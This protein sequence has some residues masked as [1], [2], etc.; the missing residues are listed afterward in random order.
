[1]NTGPPKRWKRWLLYA[2]LAVFVPVVTLV[3]VVQ[4]GLAER[5]MRGAIVGG[6]ERITGGQVQLGAFRFSFRA[7]RAELDDLT[8]HGLEPE[9]A[10]PLFHAEHI[11][12]DIRVLSFLRGKVAPEEV[13][14]DRPAVHLRFDENGRSN[15]P[16]PQ[17][18]AR[19]PGEPLQRRIFDVGIRRL[20]LNNGTLLFNQTRM[21]LVAQ[22]GEFNFALDIREPVPGQR[23]YVCD[24]RWEH[25]TLVIRRYLPF[26]SDL[27]AKL[28]LTRNSLD[29][30]ELRW[31]LPHSEFKVA[32]NLA[33]FA[34]PAWDFRY[35]GWLGLEDLRKIMRK[36]NAP[37]GQV[38]FLGEGRYAE[39]KFLTNG[40]YVAREVE[41]PYRWFHASGIESRGSYRFENGR[42]KVPDFQAKVLGGQTQGRVTLEVAGQKWRAE[43]RSQGVDLAGVLRAVDHEG[44]PVTALHW[45]GSVDVQDVTTWTAD[46]KHVE[47]RGRMRW[48]PPVTPREG[49]IPAAGS[50]RYQYAMD[51]RALELR[52]SEISTPAGHIVMQGRLS[53][54]DSALQA[55][56]DIQDLLPWNDFINRLR[57]PDA[58]PERIAGRAQ[59]QGRVLGDLEGPTFAGHVKGF[60]GAYG[61]FTADEIEGDV[62]YSPEGFRLEHT[63]ARRGRSTAQFDL[64][65]EL[66]DWSFRPHSQWSLEV[67]LERADTD[68]LQ[69]L[70]KTSY[71]ARGLLTGQFRGR[72]TRSAPEFTG[73]FDVTEGQAWGFALDRIRG[74]LGVRSDEV[75]IDNAEVRL[76]GGRMTGDFLYRR[77]DQQIAFEIAGSALPVDRIARLEKT[78]LPLG[79]LLH[80]QIRGEGPLAAPR[81]TGTLRI[82]DFS[83]AGEMQ[84]SLEGTLRSDGRRLH[85]DLSSA[86]A[87]GRVQGKLDLTLQGDYPLAG[88]LLVENV[89]LDAFIKPAFRIQELTGHSRVDGRFRV[90]GALK[91]PEEITV[92]AD[93]SSLKLD[94]QNV[95][96]ENEGPLRFTYSRQE[97]RIQQAHLRGTDTDFEIS[98]SARFTGTRALDLRLAGT[99]NLQLLGGFFP[100]L[101]ARGAAQTNA[102]IQGTVDKPRI[103]GRARVE[104]AA[105]TYG[106]F[107]AGLSHI[108]GAFIFDSSRLL[109]D[110]IVAEAGGG[111]IVFGGSLTYGEGPLRY[112]VSAR[113]TRVR[114][115]Y[116]EGMSWLAGGQVQFSGT[117]RGGVLAGSV[118]VERVFLAENFDF[119]RL[120]G[121]SRGSLRAS[122]TTSPYLRNLH[123][124][125]DAASS[126]DARLE[127]SGARFDT[128]ARVRVRGTWEN[129]ILLGNLRLLSGEFQFRGNRYRLTRGDIIFSKPFRIDPELNIEAVTIIRQYE[130]TLNFT[131]S[132]SKLNLAYRSDPP[133]PS[134]DIIGL[135]ALGRTG[136]E[137]KLRAGPTPVQSPEMGAT[138]LLSEAIAS[139]IGGRVE[140]LFGISRFKVDPFLAGIGNEQNAS[141]RL[142]IEQQV[143]RDLTI[144]YITN[145]TS[146]QQQVIQVEYN[147]RGDVSLVLLR[148]Q[149]GTFSVS[150]KFKKRFK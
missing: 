103:N 19:P 137:S 106:D 21:P 148:D 142:T 48:S 99:V 114:L 35:Q 80:F 3:A 29:L 146:T 14:L 64:W 125:I 25:V 56:L 130:I 83:A 27:T 28:T 75:R 121:G 101:D 46:F 17:L 109:F 127:W 139:Q 81:S 9:G 57:G 62:T 150:V 97:V 136:E 87:T 36:P 104:D 74:R 1:M 65:L 123:F 89:D 98:G 131:G 120:L 132:A 143:T 59:W 119:A 73:L 111:Q 145:V 134:S 138:T 78:R 49:E 58:V 91:R 126:P 45:G 129:P 7:L 141:A 100:A 26:T 13:L 32:A 37:G 82:V 128:E 113:A 11:L 66:H 34:D 94:Y 22:G 6:L 107:P 85:L 90:S 33:S 12:V 79:G 47:S 88:D 16:G 147:V 61:R 20:R 44:F 70:F 133:L 124:D 93:I 60:E 51:R 31:K 122:A 30:T 23:S 55:T 5:W 4:T 135:L 69:A 118:V 108:T 140:R 77:L 39:K 115:R 10:P 43:T 112:D 41:L 8:I 96:L 24:L 84:G 105:A 40:R 144:T 63:R 18:A 116:P 72:G 38:E 52:E 117:K 15:F 67:N 110:N 149:N 76:N 54:R 2:A 53:A 92:D 86:M 50:F 68:E 95:K 102:V 42:V 71:P